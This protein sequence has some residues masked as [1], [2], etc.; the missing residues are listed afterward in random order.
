MEVLK[1]ARA[2]GRAAGSQ[3]A[4]LAPQTTRGCRADRLHPVG[5]ELSLAKR[6]AGVEALLEYLGS[7][8]DKLG[9][10]PAASPPSNIGAAEVGRPRALLFQAMGVLERASRFSADQPQS[11]AVAAALTEATAAAQRR[12]GCLGLRCWCWSSRWPVAFYWPVLSSSLSSSLLRARGAL[13]R[14]IVRSASTL[15]REMS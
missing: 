1:K 10:S 6:V 15:V 13:E 3:P 9:K 5:G 11:V 4:T 7:K 8:L 14:V 2:A 12:C